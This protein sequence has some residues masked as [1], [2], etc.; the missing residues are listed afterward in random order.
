MPGV[1]TLDDPS[2]GMVLNDA[3][4]PLLLSGVACVEGSGGGTAGRV[5]RMGR[6]CKSW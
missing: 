4:D 2:G 1:S 6:R 5:S 3:E